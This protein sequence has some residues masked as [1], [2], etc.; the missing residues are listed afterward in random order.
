VQA[1]YDRRRNRWRALPPVVVTPGEQVGPAGHVSVWTGREWLLWGGGCCGG[2]QRGGSAYDPRSNRWR[3]LPRSPLGAR[4]AAGAW[5]GH[6]LVIAGG[7]RED[8]GKLY[9]DAAAYD[10]IG[11]RWRRLAPMPLP[12][13]DMTA[14]WN[15]SEV[16]FLGGRGS[17]AKTA[18]RCWLAYSLRTDRWRTLAAAGFDRAGHVAVWTGSQ[19]LVWGGRRQVGQDWARLPFGERWNPRTGRWLRL[20]TAPLHGRADPA[21]VWTGRAFIVWGGA[22]VEL[23]ADPSYRDGATYRP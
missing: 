22:G 13:T 17:G 2:S 14:V 4:S 5:T 9:R 3:P 20:P 6:E 1:A 15:G 21:G 23:T 19:V 8:D 18:P 12:R 16:L 10:P 7:D 11:N